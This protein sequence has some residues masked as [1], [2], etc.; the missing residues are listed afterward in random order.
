MKRLIALLFAL[1][2]AVMPTV[3]E[4]QEFSPYDYYVMYTVNGNYIVF[5]FPDIMLYLPI[6]WNEAI[7]VEQ[8]DSGTSFYQTASHDR[9][10]EEGLAGGGFLFELCASED[11]SFRELPVFE[12][13][14]YSENAGL[15][16]YLLLP[17]DYR[18]WPNDAAI[19]AEYDVMIDQVGAVAEMEKSGRAC[20]SISMAL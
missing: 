14:S 10:M 3:A 15:H 1:I 5:D 20:T 17:S 18:V 19:R 6:E 9:F 2:I 8:S 13:L 4:A 11:E 7:T 16:F 12:Y